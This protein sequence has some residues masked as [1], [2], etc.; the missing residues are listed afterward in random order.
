MTFRLKNLLRRLRRRFFNRNVSFTN[1]VIFYNKNS[2]N[3]NDYNDKHNILPSQQKAAEGIHM[4]AKI[5]LLLITCYWKTVPRKTV[6][7]AQRGSVTES[8]RLRPPSMGRKSFRHVQ[9]FVKRFPSP[10]HEHAEYQTYS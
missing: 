9:N 6:I 3:D 4:A 5:N 7:L 2:S 8:V 1:S 10:M